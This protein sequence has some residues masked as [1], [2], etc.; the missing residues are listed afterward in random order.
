[1]L[2]ASPGWDCPGKG[3][4]ITGGSGGSV[5]GWYWPVGALAPSGGCG[6]WSCAR[7]ATGSASMDITGKSRNQRIENLQD[8]DPDM[9]KFCNQRVSAT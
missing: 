9:A 3:G 6:D 1:M 7:A 4:S 5:P 2:S 8:R